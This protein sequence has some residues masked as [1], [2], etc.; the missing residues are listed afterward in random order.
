MFKNN[1]KLIDDIKDQKTITQQIKGN[2]LIPS[3]SNPEVEMYFRKELRSQKGFFLIQN[4]FDISDKLSLTHSDSKSI[5]EEL[6]DELKS[7]TQIDEIDE[8]TPTSRTT[9]RTNF[10]KIVNYQESMKMI[11]VLSKEDPN[12]KKGQLQMFF[13]DDMK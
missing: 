13:P 10:Q 4:E 6:R 9:M 1:K 11:R 2:A 12:F 5:R 3:V 7:L 8:L